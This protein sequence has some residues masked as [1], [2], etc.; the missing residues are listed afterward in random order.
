[1]LKKII[2]IM[3]IFTLVLTCIPIDL[4]YTNSYAYES[5][6]E[7]KFSISNVDGNRVKKI[8]VEITKPNTTREDFK[9]ILPNGYMVEG[10]TAD[11]M[12]D[13]N[14]VY[15][16]TVYESASSRKTFSYTVKD[17]GKSNV[18]PS[19]TDNETTVESDFNLN[20]LFLGLELQYDYEETKC[21]LHCDLDKVRN[22]KIDSS[23]YKS[24]IIN[25]Y[26]SDI[27]P[28]TYSDYTIYVEDKA[29]SVRIERQGDF[30]LMSIWQTISEES[31][32]YYLSYRGFSFTTNSKITCTPQDHLLSGNDEGEIVVASDTSKKVFTYNIE[33]FD[34]MRPTAEL[35]FNSNY[36]FEFKA[37]DNK[38]L[39]YYID[40]K[41]DYIDLYNLT[42]IRKLEDTIEERITYNG[43]YYFTFVDNSGN[44]FVKNIEITGRVTPPYVGKLGPNI[45]G[46]SESLKIFRNT[47]NPYNETLL[48]QAH[49]KNIFPSYMNGKSK[50]SF[51]P[52]DTISRAEMVTILCRVNDLK[53][54]ITS[55]NKLR[56]TDI[57]GH[58]AQYYIGMG[59]KKRYIKGKTRD[60]FDPDGILSKAEFCKMITN[61]S[62]IKSKISA[63]PSVNNYKFTDINTNFAKVDILKLANRD[64]VYGS[65]SDTFS[66]EAPITREEVVYAIN[67]I[68]G[69]NPSSY[70]LAYMKSLFEKHYNFNDISTSPYYN[71][72]VVSVMGMFREIER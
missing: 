7:A 70:E 71:D 9:I 15:Y 8:H 47:G 12:A 68:Y 18:V 20:V 59:Y 17:I 19:T 35:Y 64:L 23:T 34:T 28:G 44:R 60:T 41:G 37:K 4:I 51:G 54:D 57:T 69:L 56:F 24:N 1:M 62:A 61:I 26:I 58:W 33:S 13:I 38:S 49:Y 42:D 11:Y 25:H 53:Y 67:R 50:N 30:Y 5:N 46:D 43:I 22:I 66:P 21:L 6:L 29:L 40:Y 3:C 45:H 14:G 2:T 10:N 63:I 36:Y 48:N 65:S 27:A 39:D 52:K 31:K 32:M 16:F 72:I 55:V